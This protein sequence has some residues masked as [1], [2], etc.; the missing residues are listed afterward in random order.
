MLWPSSCIFAMHFVQHHACAKHSLPPCLVGR[1]QDRVLNMPD[2][3]WEKERQRKD[4]AAIDGRA[5]NM[6][7]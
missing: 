1:S 4:N 3:M 6:A 7:K 5:D 2:D